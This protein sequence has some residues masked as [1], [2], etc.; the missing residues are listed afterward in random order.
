MVNLIEDLSVIKCSNL[1]D[2]S[3]LYWSSM[4]WAVNR[5]SY[6][7]I[8]MDWLCADCGGRVTYFI[9]V[10]RLRRFGENWYQFLAG[11]LK[12]IIEMRRWKY[13]IWLRFVQ[14][15]RVLTD[16]TGFLLDVKESSFIGLFEWLILTNQ[17]ILFPNL[18]KV[19][20]LGSKTY[21][22]NS[23]KI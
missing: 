17:H 18:N 6:L 4:L 8:Y 14:L 16:I 19:L 3:E 21:Q 23:F 22:G 2:S 10:I 11:Q 20:Y 7:H 12:R 9:E 5:D 1:A 15:A 13:E